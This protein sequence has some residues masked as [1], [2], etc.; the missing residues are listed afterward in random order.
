M[1]KRSSEYCYPNDKVFTSIPILIFGAIMSKV[2]PGVTS[3]WL[4]SEFDSGSDVKGNR[5]PYLVH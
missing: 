2:T 1:G 4:L 3:I 5:V